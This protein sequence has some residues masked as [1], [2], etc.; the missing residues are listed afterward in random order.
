MIITDVRL[1]NEILLQNC[2]VNL[3]EEKKECLVQNKK[4]IMA[5]LNITDVASSVP[6]NF[7]AM[8]DN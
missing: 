8:V 4:Y 6:Q 2:Q 7:A 1:R 5:K 3:E